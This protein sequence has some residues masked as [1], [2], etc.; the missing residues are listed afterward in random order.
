LYQ[1]LIE[2]VRLEVEG[3]DLLQQELDVAHERIASLEEQIQELRRE[4]D[5]E[6]I[7]MTLKEMTAERSAMQETIDSLKQDLSRRT[8]Q[9]RTT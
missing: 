5:E 6:G 9:V 1:E 4:R 2:K 8:H 3:Q 7:P